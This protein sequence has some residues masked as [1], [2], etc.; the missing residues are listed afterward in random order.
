MA[1]LNWS[2]VLIH[3]SA[4]PDTGGL[5]ADGIRHYH[6]EVKGWR[7]VGYHYLVELEGHR[8]IVVPGR[9]ETQDGA[10]CPGH[11]QTALGVCMVGDFTDSPPSLEQLRVTAE[12]CA[13]LCRRHGI[14][15]L[16]IRPHRAF[17]RTE[18]PG[19]AFTDHHMLVLRLEVSRLLRE[20]AA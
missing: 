16:D 12:L 1:R 11:N 10:H 19:K 9:P 13:D 18:C 5:D 8:Y 7:D 6:V 15:S 2:E 3:H 4:G 14:R 17:R 20:A